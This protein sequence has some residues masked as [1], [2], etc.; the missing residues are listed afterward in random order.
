MRTVSPKVYT[1]EYYLTDCTGF[2]EFKKTCGEELEDRF[3]EITECIKV[4]K[5]IKVLDIGCGRGEMILYV[6]KKGAIATGI[7]YSKNAI[8]LANILRAKQKKEI[9]DKMVFKV[10]NSKKLSYKDSSFDMVILSDIIEH[11][12]PEELEI[13]FA[14]IKRVLKNNGEIIMHTAPNKLFY[15]FFYK[16]YSYP[17]SS[18]IVSFWNVFFGKT[19][20]NIQN[21]KKLRA[22][23]HKVMHVNEQTYF[24][25][26][27]LF[28]KYEFCGLLKSTNV[29]SKKTEI[30]IKDKIY[31]F[32]VYL[33][34]LSRMFPL[35]IFFGGD[36]ISIV[37]N[38]RI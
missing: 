23:S 10:M 12:Y 3:K 18:L 13:V 29:T 33:H 2:E 34:P 24:S 32:I 25:L 37:K 15:D 7:D 38:K 30:S 11:L 36:F 31:N 9:R 14:E 8:V 28:N 26:N 22:D 17:I 20:P 1:K 35:N 4:K 27:K 21:P 16:Y 5:N 19:Y 6:A